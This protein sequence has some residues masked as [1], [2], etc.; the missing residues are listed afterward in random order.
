MGSTTDKIKGKANEMVGKVKQSSD[1]P[2]T[3]AEGHMQERKGEA[4]QV[5]G[6]VKENLKDRIDKA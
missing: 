3:R 5:K 2:S 4:Q 6:K 1:K